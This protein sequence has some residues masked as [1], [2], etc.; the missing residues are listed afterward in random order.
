MELLII[1]GLSGA[2]N[3]RASD[4]CE[5]MGFYCVDNLPSPLLPRFAE[6]ALAAADRYDRIALVI[7][8]HSDREM[9]EL[10]EALRGLSLPDGRLSLLFLDSD[11]DTLVRRYK[12]SR[13]PHPLARRGESIRDAIERERVLLAPLRERAD[14]IVDTAG[15]SLN[16]LRAVLRKFVNGPSQPF[17]VSLM[18]FGYKHGLPPEA[19]IV[20]DVRCLPNPYYLP[21]LR[22]KTGLDAEV[23]DYVFRTDQ[24]QKFLRL[25]Q[26]GLRTALPLFASDRQE[27][28]VAVGCTGGQHR[29][30][31]VTQA[32][33][34]SLAED[35]MTVAVS[36]RE[37][38]GA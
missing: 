5:D 9:A 11:T 30:V 38:D 20:L 29:S 21:E 3:T 13:R 35:G 8:I 24:S 1:T 18:S 2:G 10:D 33:A 32:L 28:T 19:D 26:D 31:A 23:A 34:A 12:E 6:L 15:M 36:H 7:D 16:R 25:L 22:E 27:I 17:T 14:L 4:V 37:L